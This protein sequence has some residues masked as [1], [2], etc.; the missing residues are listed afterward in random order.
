MA[1]LP[2]E[3][4]KNGVVGGDATGSESPLYSAPPADAPHEPLERYDPG[5]PSAAAAEAYYEVMRRRRTVRMFSDKPVSRETI[6]WVIRSAGTAPERG[7]SS[8]GGLS[9]CRIRR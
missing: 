8:R 5:V 9:R 3:D 2:R 7:I 6:E 4:G 1:D